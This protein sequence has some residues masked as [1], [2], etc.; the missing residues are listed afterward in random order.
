MAD[1]NG[2]YMESRDARLP[3]MPHMARL[4]EQ[5]PAERNA[6]TQ[7]GHDQQRLSLFVCVSSAKRPPQWLRVAGL[8]HGCG[9]VFPLLAGDE[10]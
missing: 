1:T 2:A 8:W 3:K 10:R 9:C 5:A 7:R 4:R 6:R